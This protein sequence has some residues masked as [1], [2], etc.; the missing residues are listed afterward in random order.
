MNQISEEDFKL[1]LRQDANKLVK[2]LPIW[3]SLEDSL[4]EVGEHVL[5][6][7][8]RYVCESFLAENQKWQ[9]NGEQLSFMAPTHWM[10]F[11]EP[12]SV[13]LCR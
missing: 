4:P 5:V 1:M 6:S 7:D 12:P 11:P 3:I 13:K 10:P 8:G 9:R 2:L